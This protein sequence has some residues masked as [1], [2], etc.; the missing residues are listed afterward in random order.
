[1]ISAFLQTTP[2]LIVREWKLRQRT[3]LSLAMVQHAHFS[4]SRRESVVSPVFQLD[5]SSFSIFI[6]LHNDVSYNV[7]NKLH[8]IRLQLKRD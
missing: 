6:T 4:S 1:M 3:A 7:I 8:L 5:I 2:M